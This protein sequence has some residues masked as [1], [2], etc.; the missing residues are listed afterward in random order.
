MQGSNLVE[1][2]PNPEPPPLFLFMNTG[3]FTFTGAELGIEARFS[4]KFSSHLFFTYLD[5]REKT[6]GRP[7]QKWDA[8]FRFEDKALFVSLQGQYITDYFSADLSQ[9]P[10]PSYFLLNARA[11]VELSRFCDIFL[12]INNI[13]D[14]DYLIYL[15]LPGIE[16]GSYPM[17]KRNVN[18]GITLKH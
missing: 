3:K 13:L 12:D 2:A 14:T 9:N 11:S 8:S 15:D 7:G 17:P 1:T 16:T 5:P 6:K 4:G 10:L 18:L